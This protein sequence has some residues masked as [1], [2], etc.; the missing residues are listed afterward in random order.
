MPVSEDRS[1]PDVADRHRRLLAYALVALGT[2]YAISACA[3]LLNPRYDATLG[4]V[5]DGFALL[6]IGLIV[7]VFIW[8]ARNRSRSDWHLYKDADGFVAQTIARAQGVS[9]VVTFLVLVLLEPLNR[10]S[11]GV[12]TAFVFDALLAIMIFTFSGT[13]FVLDSAPAGESPR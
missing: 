5:A 9:W 6:A 3:H 2:R 7:P 11:E 12:S 13:F 1:V 8:K 10:V 4:T